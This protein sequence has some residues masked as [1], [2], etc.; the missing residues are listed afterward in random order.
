M[1]D[2]KVTVV[3]K[4]VVENNEYS[5][6]EK[7]QFLLDDTQQFIMD[8]S[9]F[10]LPTM[11]DYYLGNIDDVLMKKIEAKAE[12][13]EQDYA[14]D[15][16]GKRAA[17][18]SESVPYKKLGMEGYDHK[19]GM[20]FLEATVDV[21]DS[22][23]EDGFAGG[24]FL[25]I[26][27]NNV[28][29]NSEIVQ[30]L[31]E[32]LL[33]AIKGNEPLKNK[34]ASEG[35][36]FTL[37]L[38][39]ISCPNGPKWA[40]DKKDTNEVDPS[41]GASQDERYYYRDYANSA[42]VKFANVC[43]KLR[44]TQGDKWLM[45]KGDAD[46]TGEG[47][48]KDN[49]VVGA[50]L[51]AKR[52]QKIIKDNGNKICFLMEDT[53]IPSGNQDF[54]TTSAG[55]NKR[56]DITVGL[57]KS[58]EDAGSNYYKTG[59]N[60]IDQ[61]N[62]RRFCGQAYVKIDD[63]H[64]INLAKYVLAD[65]DNQTV[66]P[67][68]AY[69]GKNSGIFDLNRYDY[70][71]CLWADAF[72][73]LA[74]S[75]DD[76][77]DIMKE[78]FGLDKDSLHKWTVTIG[79]VTMF[80][81]P[82]NIVCT[83]VVES[84][85]APM[86]RARGSLT[87]EGRRE[88]RN[89]TLNLFFNEE[90][91][92]N[93][94]KYT[95]NLPGEKNKDDLPLDY[96]MYG[97][98]ALVAQFKFTPFLPIENDYINDTLGIKA[99]VFDSLQINHVP[100]Y[101][102]LYQVTLSM[103]EFDYA[104]YMPEL[105]YFM[106]YGS[107]DGNA[108]AHSINWPVM[109]YYYQRCLRRGQ[110]IRDNEYKYNSSDY[111]GMILGNK[112]SLVPMA[113]RSNKIKFY[114]AQK[115]Y[116]DKM[117]E[118]K[119]AMITGRG[120][121]VVYIDDAEVEE[122]KKLAKLYD[123][124]M[125]GVAESG[126][127]DKLNEHP[128]EM[129][130]YWSSGVLTRKRTGLD[131]GNI[132]SLQ[133]DG[134]ENDFDPYTAK[135]FTRDYTKREKQVNL[136]N[137]DHYRIL[138][139]LDT[140]SDYVNEVNKEL[141]EAHE[142]VVYDGGHQSVRYVKNVTPIDHKTGTFEVGVVIQ[143]SDDY[144]CV[145]DNFNKIRSDATGYVGK[146]HNEFFQSRQLY[147]PFKCTLTW[148]E[149]ENDYTFRNGCDFMLDTE[150]PD[151]KFLEWC[152]DI[153]N[154]KA[155][156]DAKDKRMKELSIGNMDSLKYEEYKIDGDYYIT[157]FAA[158]LNNHVSKVNISNLSGTSAQYL[159][160][161]DTHFSMTIQ[162]TNRGVAQTFV[163]IPKYCARIMRE[164]HA[165]LPYAP[166]RVNSEITA[167]LGVNDILMQDA[168]ITTGS[169][170]TGVYTVEIT[171]KSI[172]RTLRD[173][174]AMDRVQLDNAGYNRGVSATQNKVK[175]MMELKSLLQKAEVY[176]DLELPTLDEMRQVG[177]DFLK[178]K[179]DDDRK[180]VDP[181]FYFV[182]PYTLSCQIIREYIINEYTKTGRE[183]TFT[184]RFGASIGVK[185]M[186]N[187]GYKVETKNETLEK[188]EEII[189]NSKKKSDNDKNKDTEENLKKNDDDIDALLAGLGSRESWAVN[190]D[191][192][193]VFLEKGYKNALDKYNVLSKAD[194]EKIGDQKG[195][196]DQVVINGKTY[197]KNDIDYLK[198]NGHAEATPEEI[199]K[200]LDESK[201]DKKEDNNI[202]KKT[203]IT[204][205]K[206]EAKLS[207]YGK[208]VSERLQPA[209]EAAKGIYSYLEN[210]GINGEKKTYES[211]EAK[212]EAQ[213]KEKKYDIKSE[214]AFNKQVLDL[215][216]TSTDMSGNA[217]QN[218]T[219][220]YKNAKAQI[221]QAVDKFFTKPDVSQFLNAIHIDTTN[222]KFL[223]ATK[224]IIFS[225][226]CAATGEKEYSGKTEEKDWLPDYSFYGLAPS[227]GLQDLSVK[228]RVTK[229][230]EIDKAVVF[231][232]FGIKLYDYNSLITMTNET[233][234]EEKPYD[235]ENPV[236]S[237]FYPIDPFYR[238]AE[239]T[240]EYQKLCATNPEAC[241]IAY[242]RIMLFW[243]AK[244]CIEL[245]AFPSMVS[246]VF[247]QNAYNELRKVYEYQKNDVSTAKETAIANN[248]SFFESRT[249]AVDAGKIWAASV[250][251]STEG[252]R[253]IWENIE[254]KDYGALNGYINSCSDPNVYI[255]SGE[256]SKITI[257]KMVH[258]IDAQ[259]GGEN[260]RNVYNNNIASE[261]LK[262]TLEAKYID[263]AED[264]SKFIPHS[265]HDMVVNNCSGRMLRAFPT[266]YMCFIDEGREIGQW[267]LHDNFYTTSSIIDMQIV[268]SRKLPADTATITMSNF[269]QSYTTEQ[270][271]AVKSSGTD[272]D[273]VYNSIFNKD[274]YAQKAER[275]RVAAPPEARIMLR[276]GARMHIRMGYG[277]NPELM[278]V[279]FNGAIA[280]VSAEETV[281]IVAQGDGIELMNPITE[282]L[283]A[284]NINDKKMLEA[285]NNGTPRQIMQ[286]IMTTRGGWLHTK[287]EG[288]WAEVLMDMNPFG[289][290]HFGGIHDN[291]INSVHTHKIEKSGSTANGTGEVGPA[292][293]SGST[294]M[295][296]D[297]AKKNAAYRRDADGGNNYNKVE[298]DDQYYSVEAV[299]NIYEACD[300]PYWGVYRTAG[301][302]VPE[303][304]IKMFQRTP[305]EI[306]NICKSAAPDFVCGVEPFDFRSTIFIGAPRYYYAYSYH[307]EKNGTILEKRKP[308][309]QY[310]IYTSYSDIIAN[311]MKASSERV[312]TVVT[313][314]YSEDGMGT[315]QKHIEPC[316][317]DIDI[318]PE[319][320][321]TMVYD[322]G[323]L[324]ST[325]MKGTSWLLNPLGGSF[326]D[327]N[328][329]DKESSKYWTARTMS[330]NAMADS[331]K[332]MYC[333]DIVLLGDPSV[334]PFDKAYINDTFEGITGVVGIK[335]VVHS[336]NVSDGFLTTI[337]PDCIVKTEGDKNE[338]IANRAI[339]DAG[340]AWSS[341]IGTMTYVA[342]ALAM[343]TQPSI[344]KALEAFSV[345]GLLQKG[346]RN[347]GKVTEEALDKI[348]GKITKETLEKAK[349]VEKKAAN[350]LKKTASKAKTWLDAGKGLACCTGWGL[351]LIVA[352]TAIQYIVTHSIGVAISEYIQNMHTLKV[353]PVERFGIPYTAGLLGNKGLV[354]SEHAQ[355]PVGGIKEA[356]GNFF[357]DHP[358]LGFLTDIIIASDEV[359]NAI[360]ELKIKNNM[361]NKD[362]K[363]PYSMEQFGK[364]ITSSSADEIDNNNYT[365]LCYKDRAL[366]D[367]EK[368]IAQ[369]YFGVK[370]AKHWQSIAATNSITGISQD[371]RLKPY[372][373][374][375]FLIIA[376][377]DP[378]VDKSNCNLKT[379]VMY[380][381]NGEERYLKTIVQ[382]N[383][384]GEEVYNVPMLHPEALSVLYELVRRTKL[385]LYPLNAG[386]NNTAYT[387]DRDKRIVVTSALKAGD[388]TLANTGFCFSLQVTPS[389]A[390]AFAEAHKEF[391]ADVEK[392]LK[393]IG[394][395]T[396]TFKEIYQVTGIGSP[397]IGVT[398][399]MPKIDSLQVQGI[400]DKE[401]EDA[402]RQAEHDEKYHVKEQEEKEAKRQRAIQEKIAR[403]EKL[404]KEKERKQ[405][406]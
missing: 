310:H 203:K 13:Y 28:S 50:D 38:A 402:K 23:I 163:E 237:K 335:E 283:E 387:E 83:S 324:A 157:D 169:N 211:E 68:D 305:W 189:K 321:K 182:Y 106:Q 355:H 344:G 131:D 60:R 103:N 129:N 243:L 111:N 110:T 207:E 69:C 356:V 231:G 113:F 304:N 108:F 226:A 88:M 332:D 254:R 132:I 183:L 348:D 128:L 244:L 213:K 334:K 374:S 340:A 284:G 247:N 78:V 98:R 297:A 96:Y 357:D 121:D 146:A 296:G 19:N 165:I 143:L 36:H 298:N 3:E 255:G 17:F 115:D 349:G 326:F 232:I 367:E 363:A 403:D 6:I 301:E 99:I 222:Q 215:Q 393:A 118:T 92:I 281:T 142:M 137:D 205:T 368:G 86:L 218:R 384:N 162:T 279:L 240:V 325:G 196:Y 35:V 272:W 194:K 353:F 277:A 307:V 350:A 266:F 170:Q 330:I 26:N 224:A 141:G 300:K 5:A 61:E 53:S 401:R 327:K 52:L 102:K 188:Q 9:Y 120:N 164:Y 377:E 73:E 147:I 74:E 179:F 152:R 295:S 328:F 209:Y 227:K 166:L 338:A 134:A 158:V 376:H 40:Y 171:F 268:K 228:E 322:T 126:A 70:K 271:Y 172:D 263:A 154:I 397:N 273:D 64:Y 262:N 256:R 125:T 47:G 379:E 119:L 299:Q 117:V 85:E 294:D 386:D 323:L 239:K 365:A 276:P 82:T 206:K 191:I 316:Y 319:C 362:G 212:E 352:E 292:G 173:R 81:P 354:I 14:K 90:R 76:R 320:Q 72:H 234:I 65:I 318:Y 359:D 406:Q 66:T 153:E 405:Q 333:G 101:P 186:K 130:G 317:A 210:T 382:Q 107:I 400:K 105:D 302:V 138:D 383:A 291:L 39:G 135:T 25:D 2:D 114:V 104:A 197:D 200:V 274:A 380:M 347:A 361:I 190:Q 373:D 392:D 178:Y 144:N 230:D 241:A 311:G 93:G 195:Q 275:Q 167:F 123:I 193:T 253:V 345:M 238:S 59:S 181:D 56:P 220:S 145:D 391:A 33:G 127:L 8:D 159:G 360:N 346:A 148:D 282:D 124:I 180:Y 286:R 97:L 329:K 278:P 192:M 161:E 389:C 280:E 217:T 290:Y 184:D 285:C 57:Q 267:R 372:I 48:K 30:R 140:I 216:E 94:F 201:E 185:T 261:I 236:A 257:R 133:N 245:R 41:K 15:L 44:E 337:S 259:Y 51:A 4:E 396:E 151:V 150:S 62:T 394:K 312:K 139:F 109:R 371:P 89:L 381:P 71:N 20:Y 331:I 229:Y 358:V 100:D 198:E 116:L 156:N 63:D 242:M 248:I 149:N 177:Y 46:Y 34:A 54:P 112:T 37:Q 187:Q 287:L 343:K 370:S 29:G 258:A 31:N 219:I 80:V 24:N 84:H 270:E 314:M 250:L 378:G 32:N 385:K 395:D 91:G 21:S 160:G 27:I 251:A 306:A 309:E 55:Y 136:S 42:S 288:T 369:T 12:G 45:D 341:V 208:S 199:A 75:L 366:T 221:E 339:L 77:K 168:R 249:H 404:R 49:M 87:K 16:D 351:A 122:A 336:M 375:E 95:Q 214:K 43:G 303:I 11:G 10:S 67:N 246:D 390:S 342:S 293:Q 79:D 58:L 155:Q 265:F 204:G 289:I 308:F 7:Q 398:V 176:P 22:A 18:Y 174:E 175:T 252:D 364:K 313:G 264:P 388:T 233:G 260:S 269:F 235:E 202:T 225:A 315:T 399:L 223:S 1:A